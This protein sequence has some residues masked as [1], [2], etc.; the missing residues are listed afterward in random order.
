MIN[1]PQTESLVTHY[2]L[3]LLGIGQ[4]MDTSHSNQK[5]SQKQSS[6]CVKLVLNNNLLIHALHGKQGSDP[7][8]E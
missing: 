7:N 4:N 1:Y 8:D 6:I 2:P 3:H 5:T